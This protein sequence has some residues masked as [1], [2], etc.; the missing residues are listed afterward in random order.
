MKSKISEILVFLTIILVFFTS[1]NNGIIYDKTYYTDD[2]VKDIVKI[3]FLGNEYISH[4]GFVPDSFFD[5]T[6]YIN[7]YKKNCLNK[8]YLDKTYYDNDNNNYISQNDNVDLNFYNCFNNGFFVNGNIKIN[9][10]N[11]INHNDNLLFNYLI[12]Y[13]NTYLN[14]GLPE[15]LKVNGSLNIQYQLNKVSNIENISYYTDKIR[16]NNVYHYSNLIFNDI[17]LD[18]SN[19]FD[20]NTYSYNYHGNF[21]FE[22]RNY[23]FRTLNSI[24]GTISEFPK[25]GKF[26]IINNPKNTNDNVKIILNI[27]NENTIEVKYYVYFGK[28]YDEDIFY[29]FDVNWNVILDKNIKKMKFL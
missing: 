23:I 12:Q 6:Y 20:N 7:S 25:Q 3:S 10:D 1:C 4:I 11:F 26:E 14:I 28:N 2:K 18:I 16:F 17:Y 27:L 9:I 15:D 5:E 8:G 21:D 24:S 19:N 22:K 29:I 13:N